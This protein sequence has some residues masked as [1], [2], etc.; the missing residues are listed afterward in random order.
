MAINKKLIHF[1]QKTNFENEVANNN[2]LETSIC[3]IQDTKEIWTH[4]AYYATQRSVEEIETI[5]ANSNTVTDL[6]ELLNDK[7][8]LIGDMD[9]I[10][11]GAALGMT[12]VQDVSDKQEKLESGTNIKTLNGESLLGSGDIQIDVP[13]GMTQLVNDGMFV[14][15][16][17]AN[18]ELDDVATTVNLE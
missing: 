13:T 7:Q 17:D 12:A 11:Q 2:I 16:V 10:R 5:V 1:K 6:M 4:G 15:A 9:A 3:F 18:G 8:D 14:Q